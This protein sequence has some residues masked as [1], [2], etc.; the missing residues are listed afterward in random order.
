MNRTGFRAARVCSHSSRARNVSSLCLAGVNDG[1]GKRSVVGSDSSAAHSGTVS[2]RARSYCS[3]RLNQPV[4]P[5][6]R[7]LLTAEGEGPLV[8][9]DGRVQPAV[10]V[11][12]RATPLDDG[13]VH[14]PFDHLPQDVLLQRVHDAGLAQA[15][16]ADEQ[17]DLAH[18]LLGLLPAVFEQ[19]DFVIAAGQRREP[20]RARHLDGATGFADPLDQEELDGLGDA[21]D[22]A[23]AE[24]GAVEL[25]PDQ[26][27]R[28]RAAH[29]LAG[30]GE[31][32]QP[33]RHVPCLSHQ[34]HRLLPRLHDGRPGV[35]ADP[36][37]Q[38][39]LLFAAEPLAQGV[40]VLEDVEPGS[41]G[42]VRGVLVGHR[43][44]EAG[45]EPFLAALHDRPI[46]LAN[47]LLAGLLECPHHPGLALRVET[48]QILL[49]L[50]QAAAADQDGHLPALGIADAEARG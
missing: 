3:R 21:L 23:V 46:A 44:A 14:F 40:Q 1:A 42:T 6:R 49:G 24:A 43:V 38:L 48:L 25:G 27:V 35:N 33:D 22:L 20:G 50:K 41:R 34:R 15:R 10:L 28:G 16:L 45:Q 17:D 4:E 29:D 12:R 19:V 32:L 30:L 31:V 47:G 39:Q 26:S 36:R 18:A 7:R 8:E 11:M 5:G 2:G 13:R 37:I 9:V